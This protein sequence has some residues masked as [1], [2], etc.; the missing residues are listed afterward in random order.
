MSISIE[1]FIACIVVST[2]LYLAYDNYSLSKQ[3]KQ[4]KCMINRLE[5]RVNY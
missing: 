2:L 1:L 4:L 5:N 3:N